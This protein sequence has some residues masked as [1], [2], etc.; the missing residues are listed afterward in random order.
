MSDSLPPPRTV[1]PKAPLSM[2]FPRQEYWSGLPFPS[3][4][5]LPDPG[6]KLMSHV[7]CIGR[8]VLYHW[9]HLGSPSYMRTSV[10]K[11]NTEVTRTAG[12]MD[13]E[14]LASV[15]GAAHTALGWSHSTGHSRG[16]L[17][18][19]PSHCLPSHGQ[20]HSSSVLTGWPVRFQ[21][22]HECAP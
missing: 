6:I 13:S 11:S 17:S 1:A 5:D 8:Q 9:H 22:T 4:G 7:S 3:P 20:G 15:G 16:E 2:G 12:M 14:S 21:F 18:C 10:L 19:L